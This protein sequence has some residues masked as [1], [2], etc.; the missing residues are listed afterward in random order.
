MAGKMKMGADTGFFDYNNV[1]IRVG[2]RVEHTII[3]GVVG[4][5]SQYGT[6]KAD[7]GHTYRNAN[8]VWKVLTPDDEP[9]DIEIKDELGNTVAEGQVKEESNDLAETYKKIEEEAQKE[10]K[11][12]EDAETGEAKIEVLSEKT[13]A[14]YTNE[15][16]LGEVLKRNFSVRD[17]AE[18]G[19]RTYGIPEAEDQTLAD[20]L[21]RR[22]F[23]VTAKKVVEVC[24]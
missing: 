1:P 13:L 24:L 10:W 12:T 21:R 8:E 5:V 17:L 11:V 20:E 6:I 23:E 18:H 22:G 14:D 7:N 4:V 16:L 2:D 15:E 9:I 19:I 3:T